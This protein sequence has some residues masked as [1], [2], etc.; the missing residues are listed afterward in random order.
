MNYINIFF[1]YILKFID[2]V[3][4]ES[5]KTYSF[6]KDHSLRPETEQLSIRT[7]YA[8]VKFLILD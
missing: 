5:H 8:G 3:S 7:L 6:R 1:L 2:N 4:A